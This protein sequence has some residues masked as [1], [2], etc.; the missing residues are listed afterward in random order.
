VAR[1]LWFVSSPS[2][3]QQRMDIDGVKAAIADGTLGKDTWVWRKGMAE[4]LRAGDCADIQPLLRGSSAVAPVTVAPWSGEPQPTLA[5]D[6]PL[7]APAAVVAAQAPVQ[8]FSRPAVVSGSH[9]AGTASIHHGSGHNTD[10]RAMALPVVR[11]AATDDPAEVTLEAPRPR[12]VVTQVQRGSAETSP[13]KRPTAPVDAKQDD[14]GHDER[15]KW[16]PATDTYTGLRA[17]MTRKV[18]D[19]SRNAAVEWADALNRRELEVETLA[20][21]LHVWRR[22]AVAAL[23]A[24]VLVGALALAMAWKWRA[25]ARML[26]AVPA[27]SAP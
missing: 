13:R 4:W 9:I 14:G 11:P 23:I 8:Q 27:A 21:Q 12:A 2:G 16:S 15:R 18:D 24:V 6:V 22:L 20:Q 7:P 25:A 3:Q 17:R 10:Q 5:M 1:V 19:G 26:Q